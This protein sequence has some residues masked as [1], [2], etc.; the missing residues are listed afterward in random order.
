VKPPRRLA[1]AAWPAPTSPV[2]HRCGWGA[3]PGGSRYGSAPI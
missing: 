1:Q 3:W 2:H